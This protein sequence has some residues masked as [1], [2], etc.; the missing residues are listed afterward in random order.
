MTEIKTLEQQHNEIIQEVWKRHTVGTWKSNDV[1]ADV[2][3]IIK[4]IIYEVTKGLYTEQQ[5]REA[6]KAS[7]KK[8]FNEVMD[9]LTDELDKKAFNSVS[10]AL[11]QSIQQE[12]NIV[13]KQEK[14]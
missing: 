3:N 7:F 14:V 5:V 11:S 2:H 6:C 9:G 1:P 10:E 12:W 13:I 4:D 8:V